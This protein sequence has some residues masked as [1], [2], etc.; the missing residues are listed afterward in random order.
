MSL[1]LRVPTLRDTG[2]YELFRNIISKAVD[3][4]RLPFFLDENN[5]RVGIGTTTPRSAVKM[6]VVGGDIGVSDAGAGIN[7]K[8][9]DGTKTFR[10][11]VDNDG[12]V[13][14]VQLTLLALCLFS[15]TASA[16]VG[17]TNTYLSR[18]ATQTVTADKLFQVL[19]SS[20]IG[21]RFNSNGV[22]FS[23]RVVINGDLIITGAISP[24]TAAVAA[25]TGFVFLD[26]TQTFTAP[27][28]F[29]GTLTTRSTTSLLGTI[30]GPQIIQAWAHFVGTGTVA[31]LD[32]VGVSSVTDVGVGAYRVNFST[33]MTN[34]NYG[35]DVTWSR[36]SG[37]GADRFCS[38]SDD[39]PRLTGSIDILCTNL[40]GTSA[41]TNQVYV[42]IRG[43]Q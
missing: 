42:G 6:D 4:T 8:T 11:Y 34:S 31:L 3:G 2:L 25:S 41:D 17:S 16:Q 9:P 30:V 40:T 10:I 7:V 35:A 43:R 14:S 18:Q 21:G 38:V 29:A 24:S 32:S 15:S 28:T 22:N 13:S 12:I 26:S 23:S 27:N 19:H 1:P 36:T 33:P 5:Q 37:G 39:V 20:E